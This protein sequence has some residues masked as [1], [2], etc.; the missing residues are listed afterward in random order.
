MTETTINIESVKIP[1]YRNAYGDLAPLGDS[2]KTEGLRHPITLWTDGTLISGARRL[3][4]HFLM[5]GAPG[6]SKYRRIPAVFVDNIEDAAKRLAEDDDGRLSEPMKPSELC[7][8]W[9]MMRRL[10][11]PAAVKRAEVARRRGVE[12]RRQAMRGE[13]PTGRHEYSRDYVL[14]VL[15]PPC[16]LSESSASRLWIVYTL[17]TGPA[18]DDADEVYEKRHAN[19]VE[20]MKNLDDGTVSLW[21]AYSAVIKNR[22]PPRRKETPVAVEPAPASQQLQAWGRSLPQMEGL[23]AGLV[24]LGAPNPD[25][26]WEQVGPVVTRLAAIRRDLEK[27][28]KQMR[29]TA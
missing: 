11:A 18:P 24:G 8:F 15:G 10:D 4:A 12:L 7:R 3:R 29:K 14:D 25:L 21:A 5:A 22:R 28:I 23:T 27:I 2:I 9:A 19:A 1:E 16:G 26:T 13:R 17:A 6:G 20:A